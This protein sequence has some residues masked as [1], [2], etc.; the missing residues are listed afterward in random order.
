MAT[1][2]FDRPTPTILHPKNQGEWTKLCQAAIRHAELTKD[3]RLSGLRTALATGKAEQH[4]RRMGIIHEGDLA[5]EF[6][7]SGK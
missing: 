6:P 1:R 2:I 5:R 4:L 7:T 3:R